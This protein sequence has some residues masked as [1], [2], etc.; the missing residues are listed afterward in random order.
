[1]DET[2]EMIFAGDAV[3]VSDDQGRTLGDVVEVR[4]RPSEQAIVFT[5]SAGGPPLGA[6]AAA[7]ASGAGGSA[8]PEQYSITHRQDG[9]LLWEGPIIREFV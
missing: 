7:G 5:R 3:R 2:T 1:M 8:E 6:P 9:T 4:I